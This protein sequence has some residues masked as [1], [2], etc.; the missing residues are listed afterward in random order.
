MMDEEY[1]P[2]ETNLLWLLIV[3]ILLLLFAIVV[4]LPRLIEGPKSGCAKEPIALTPPTNPNLI[5]F[6]IDM[7]IEEGVIVDAEA[8][9]KAF[10]DAQFIFDPDE[11]GQLEYWVI[12]E[13]PIAAEFNFNCP[14]D[15]EFFPLDL[16]YEGSIGI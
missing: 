14:L 2:K 11:D 5:V 12:F 6:A 7:L 1:T 9:A 16:E 3:P 13:G 4:L 10:K 8:A 15:E